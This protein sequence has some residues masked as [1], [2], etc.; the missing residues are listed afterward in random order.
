M[1]TEGPAGTS[2]LRK[3]LA[4]HSANFSAPVIT[5]SNAANTDRTSLPAFL[6]PNSAVAALTALAWKSRSVT[7]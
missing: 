4:A 1:E 5:I 2:D 7:G 6:K 3:L